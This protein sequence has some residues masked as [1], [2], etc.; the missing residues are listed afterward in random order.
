[1][2]TPKPASVPPAAPLPDGPKEASP[3]VTPVF[4]RDRDGGYFFDGLYQVGNG[5]ISQLEYEKYYLGSA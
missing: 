4:H 3:R 1:M 5:W 2:T